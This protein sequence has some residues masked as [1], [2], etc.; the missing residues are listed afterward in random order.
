V[1]DVISNNFIFFIEGSDILT[2]IIAL[3]VSKN[4]SYVV[5][6]R[7]KHCLDEFDC[8]HNQVGFKHFKFIAADID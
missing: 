1:L 2:D 7:N 8:P 3:D 4:H 6:Y 5:W